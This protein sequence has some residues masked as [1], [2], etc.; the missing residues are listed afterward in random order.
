VLDDRAKNE[1][2]RRLQELE[3][4]LEE[5]HDWGDAERAARLQA[6]LDLLAQELARAVD[7]RGRDRASPRPPNA[8]ASA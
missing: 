1:Y 3:V 5:A 6:E 4:E 2:R 7:R 8:P